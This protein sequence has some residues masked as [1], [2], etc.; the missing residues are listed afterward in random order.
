M[1][2]ELGCRWPRL[3]CSELLLLVASESSLLFAELLLELV[4]GGEGEASRLLDGFG[5]MA[6]TLESSSF[7]TSSVSSISGGLLLEVLAVDFKIPFVI[8]VGE[9]CFCC[10]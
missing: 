5:S 6:A 10:C 7:C 2:T 1:S 9:D 4:A 8:L 3:S